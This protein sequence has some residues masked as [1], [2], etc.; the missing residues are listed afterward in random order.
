MKKSNNDIIIY[1]FS[2]SGN[3]DKIAGVFRD[4]FDLLGNRIELIKAED[5]VSGNRIITHKLPAL[6]GIGFPVHAFNAPEI[7]FDMI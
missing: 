7:I 5:I 6:T 1:Y 3:T 2:G 4:E